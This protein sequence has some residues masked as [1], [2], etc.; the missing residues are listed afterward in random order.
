MASVLPLAWELPHGGKEEENK[1]QNCT[2]GTV[3]G[4]GILES[5]LESPHGRW[6]HEPTWQV[7]E[8]Y[9]DI[10]WNHMKT[11]EDTL[12]LLVFMP[13]NLPE[14]FPWAELNQELIYLGV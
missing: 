1:P 4:N 6:K 12:W 9:E 5:R 3:G 10:I 2:K 13:S 8:S 7:M 14:C 11:T